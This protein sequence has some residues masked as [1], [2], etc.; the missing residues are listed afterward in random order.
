MYW[1]GERDYTWELNLCVGDKV[2]T[3]RDFGDPEW[4]EGECKGV[5]GRFR[6]HSITPTD[7]LRAAAEAGDPAAQ[8][9]YGLRERRH[10]AAAAL[11]WFE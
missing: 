6:R 4:L 7:A 1:V 11:P 5:R 2:S 9:A 3:I 8:V 10:G